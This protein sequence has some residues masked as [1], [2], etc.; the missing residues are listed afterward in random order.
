MPHAPTD[1]FSTAAAVEILTP[2]TRCVGLAL[3]RAMEKRPHVGALGL[4]YAVEDALI[5]YLTSS[6]APREASDAAGDRAALETL[7]GARWLA[8]QRLRRTGMPPHE[9]LHEALA[10]MPQ[11][12]AP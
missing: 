5:Q 7:F 10:P 12:V 6:G 2:L 3:Y 1:P 8:Y 4:A 11:A 9:A